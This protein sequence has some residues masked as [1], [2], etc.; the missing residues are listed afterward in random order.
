MS[1]SPPVLAEAP[2]VSVVVQNLSSELAQPCSFLAVRP[3]ELVSQQ[4]RSEVQRSGS[5]APLERIDRV[6]EPNKGRS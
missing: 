2:A 1:L 3:G 5:S 4:K 6:R